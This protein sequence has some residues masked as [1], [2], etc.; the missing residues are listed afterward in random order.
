MCSTTI[1][2]LTQYQS[3]I[4]HRHFSFPIYKPLLQVQ[5]G[6]KQMSQIWAAFLACWQRPTLRGGHLIWQPP[7]NITEPDFPHSIDAAQASSLQSQAVLA[8][9]TPQLRPWPYCSVAESKM[10]SCCIWRSSCSTGSIEHLANNVTVVC[11]AGFVIILSPRGEASA[12]KSCFYCSLSHFKQC[13][14]FAVPLCRE[15]QC[16]AGCPALLWGVGMFGECLNWE[17][18]VW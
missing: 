7:S 5:V 2:T 6:R 13:T 11:H 18:L 12:I 10:M 3:F 4:I 1:Y 16:K 9:N 17:E 8:G 15:R 14:V